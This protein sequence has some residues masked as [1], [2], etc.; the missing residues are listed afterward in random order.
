MS[1]STPTVLCQYSS[2]QHVEKMID[3]I[4]RVLKRGGRFI[5]FSLHGIE[6]IEKKYQLSKYDWNVHCY[7]IKSNRWN[8]KKYRKRAIAHSMIVCDKRSSTSSFSS[9]PT[10]TTAVA[11]NEKSTQIAFN[12]TASS[13][14]NALF[15]PLR[16]GDDIPGT[17]TTMAYQQLQQYAQ[18]VTI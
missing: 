8:E 16:P 1:T 15:A 3:E 17:L 2:A 5:T 9:S 4:Y 7:R 14:T 12:D 13:I 10:T 18:E 6:E 11:D